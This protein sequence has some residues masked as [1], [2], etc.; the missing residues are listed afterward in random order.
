M[1]VECIVAGLTDE[2]RRE[3]VEHQKQWLE[4][5]GAKIV[6]TEINEKQIVITYTI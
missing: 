4:K 1:Q 3:N 2:E 6:K 5:Q